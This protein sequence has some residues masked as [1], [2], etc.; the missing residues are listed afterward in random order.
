MGG[1]VGGWWRAADFLPQGF[2]LLLVPF[3]SSFWRANDQYYWKDPRWSSAPGEVWEGRDFEE[4]VAAVVLGLGSLPRLVLHVS[5]RL[6][7]VSGCSVAVQWPP[8][9]RFVSLAPP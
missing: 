2:F 3:F 5:C 7:P 1:W 9:G 6:G 4:V 8:T